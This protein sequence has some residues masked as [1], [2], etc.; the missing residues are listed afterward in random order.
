MN[1]RLKARA[2]RVNE[3]CDLGELLRDY[4]YDVY[5]DR[6]REQQFSCDLHGQ[7][8]KP[9]ARLYGPTNSTYCWVCQKS[10]DSVAY[11]MAKENVGFREAI[12]LLE[13]RLGL[14]ALEW[15]E[16][17]S[18][19]LLETPDQYIEALANDVGVSGYG[20]TKDRV[21]RLLQTTTQERELPLNSLLAFWQ[22]FDR[23]DYLHHQQRWPDEKAKTALSKLKAKV[24]ERLGT[25]S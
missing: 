12:K 15:D 17:D 1:E 25:V 10:R 5:P 21:Y 2:Q 13:R 6:S 8:N 3:E 23:I 11:V 22:V 18:R 20:D 14:P 7:D 24:L 16:E 9:S 19:S 4:G